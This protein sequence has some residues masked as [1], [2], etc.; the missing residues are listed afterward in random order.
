MHACLQFSSSVFL[1]VYMSICLHANSSAFLHFYIYA[2][3]HVHTSTCSFYTCPQIQAFTFQYFQFHLYMSTC[4]QIHEFV[5]FVV[6][7][8]VPSDP[9]YTVRGF[10]QRDG[11]SKVTYHLRPCRGHHV[12]QPLRGVRTIPLL[13]P[14]PSVS[15]CR[16]CRIGGG[17]P[18]CGQSRLQI[19]LQQL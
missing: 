7:S 11:A 17:S 8:G 10:L 14:L 5:L 18:L 19:P 13:R 9:C 3:L 2:F 1:H 4:L 16:L 12:H 15:L 6:F